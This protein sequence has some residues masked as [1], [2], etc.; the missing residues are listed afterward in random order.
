MK[1]Y[2]IKLPKLKNDMPHGI[3]SNKVDIT[4]SILFSLFV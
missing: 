4:I 3:V 1:V 2:T